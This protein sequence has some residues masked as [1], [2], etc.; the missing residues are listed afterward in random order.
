MGSQSNFNQIASGVHSLKEMPVELAHAPNRSKKN[1]TEPVWTVC[2]SISY[3]C[4]LSNF[5]T[6]M[7]DLVCEMEADYFFFYLA[8]IP[9]CAVL[10]T[11]RY[12]F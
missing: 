8:E 1:Q 9:M 10:V 12:C 7:P 6:G 3:F 5:Y 11:S 2:G 4:S